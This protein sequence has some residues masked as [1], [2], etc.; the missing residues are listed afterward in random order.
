MKVIIFGAAGQLGKEFVKIFS[1]NENVQLFKFDI[2]DVDIS[3][4]EALSDIFRK[5]EPALVI[6]CAAHTDTV[7]AGQQFSPNFP[8][9]AFAPYNLAVLCNKYDAK[10]VHFSS[11]YVFDGLKLS[12]YTEADKCNPVNEYGKAK[13]MGEQIVLD[14]FPNSLIFRLSWVYGIGQHNFIYKLLHWSS[15]QQFLK[16]VDDE[17]SVPSSVK[18]IA[19]NVL[20]ALSKDLS[21]LYHL[22]PTGNCSRY[23]WALMIKKHLDLDVEI[24]PAKII[25]F[26]QNVKRPNFSA[27]SS[28]KLS[29]ELGIQ[30]KS[31]NEVLDEYLPQER[32]YFTSPPK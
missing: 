12:P 2:V 9:N 23:E 28:E 1:A 11:D 19:E 16:I 21:G 7:Q 8:V 3:N 15:T 22:T 14:K 4:F 17:I 10:F 29:R 13:R 24:K 5:I 20:G 32:E 26:E 6:N 31:W 18:F 30:F 27:M 25:D